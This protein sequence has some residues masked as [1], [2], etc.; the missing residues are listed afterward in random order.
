MPISDCL[1]LYKTNC[2]ASDAADFVIGAQHLQGIG[3]DLVQPLAPSGSALPG[4]GWHGTESYI[5]QFDWHDANR[6]NNQNTAC[7]NGLPVVLEF[8]N[9]SGQKY[10][11]D[12]IRRL[13]AT[14]NASRTQL[15]TNLWRHLPL[16]NP[17]ASLSIPIIK[18][19]P[20][21]SGQT[22]CFTPIASGTAGWGPPAVFGAVS[23]NVV[24]PA[25]QLFASLDSGEDKLALALSPPPVGIERSYL[26]RQLQQA[27]TTAAWLFQILLGRDFS[28]TAEYTNMVASLPNRSSDGLLSCAGARAEA[29]MTIVTSAEFKAQ[30]CARDSTCLA[31]RLMNALA[32]RQ[33]ANATELQSSIARMAPAS[34]SGGVGRGG[35]GAGVDAVADA[36]VRKYCHEADRMGLYWVP[37]SYYG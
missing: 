28:S 30:A 11:L 25:V 29:A 24:A 6:L 32:L 16:Y 5:A 2:V 13:A 36:L 15:L 9:F 12:D 14:P 7:R 19:M 4:A 20:F 21:F 18:A 3:E 17:R 34:L 37:A 1:L 22:Q 26:G 33:P 10:L 27:D 23:C 8:D 31:R 35:A